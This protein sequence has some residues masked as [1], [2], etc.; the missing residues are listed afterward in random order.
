[1]KKPA[2]LVGERVGGFSVLILVVQ[3][4]PPR[5]R[6]VIM[7]NMMVIERAPPPMPVA[8]CWLLEK[9]ASNDIGLN[10]SVAPKMTGAIII[11]Q[12]D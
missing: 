2:R 5:I 7:V 11:R 9:G 4:A 3:P 1:M 8:A 6:V 10:V 12:Q